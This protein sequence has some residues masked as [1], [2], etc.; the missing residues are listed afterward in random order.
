MADACKVEVFDSMIFQNNTARIGGA[1]YVD[2]STLVLNHGASIKTMHNYAK[3][4]GG[5]I[6]HVD[7][8]N[9]F[10]CSFT[11]N[12]QYS[13]SVVDFNL[14]DCFLQ[15][16]NVSFKDASAYRIL[17][18]NDTAGIDGQFMYG[19]LMDKCHIADFHQRIIVY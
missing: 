13:T 17:S 9:Y 1:I 5:G 15:F 16:R 14:P 6:F 8:I 11:I 4:F 12:A 2:S 7:F 19:G 18:F 10:Q 3:H